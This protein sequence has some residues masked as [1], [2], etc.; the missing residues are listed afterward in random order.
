M[1]KEISAAVTFAVK[2]ALGVTM[3]KSESK[4]V[5]MT[6]DSVTHG[7]TEVGASGTA[8]EHAELAAEGTVGWTFLKNLSS[9]IDVTIGTHATSNHVITLKPGEFA[10]FRAAGDLYGDTASGTA[11]VEYITIEA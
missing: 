4:Q 11:L 7:I 5:D 2:T 8:L 10:L 6:G 9:S 3:E 1:A